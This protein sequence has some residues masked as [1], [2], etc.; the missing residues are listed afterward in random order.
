MA[1]RYLGAARMSSGAE[2]LE[3]VVPAGR[4]TLWFA[5]GYSSPP[6]FLESP[7]R[8]SPERMATSIPGR[9]FVSGLDHP[10]G[11]STSMPATLA[12][13]MT[14]TGDTGE[15]E[16]CLQEQ[17]GQGRAGHKSK[18]G[19]RRRR[20]IDTLPRPTACASTGKT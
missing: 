14:V 3:P 19:R 13:G 11:V 5:A 9:P 2:S 17:G 4:T 6:A 8:K 18:R 10:S 12:H 1:F 16:A 15:R 20:T 7:C